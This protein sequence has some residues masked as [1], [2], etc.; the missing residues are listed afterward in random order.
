MKKARVSADPEKAAQ[1]IAKKAAPTPEEIKQVV[2]HILQEFVREE[3]GNKVTRNNMAGLT[4]Q[5]HGAIDGQITLKQ[6][7]GNTP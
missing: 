5:L 4:M 3:A 2:G 6:Q 7:E 1:A